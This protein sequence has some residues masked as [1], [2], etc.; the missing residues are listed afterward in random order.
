MNGSNVSIEMISWTISPNHHAVVKMDGKIL[1]V[2]GPEI[3]KSKRICS[4]YKIPNICIIL[5]TLRFSRKG[6]IWF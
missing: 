5:C 4:E 3:I 1:E 2:S 6:E